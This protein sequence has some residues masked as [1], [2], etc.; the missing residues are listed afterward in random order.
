MDYAALKQSIVGALSVSEC[1]V[2]ADVAAS[3]TTTSA[4]EVGHYYGLSTAV[5]LD[6]LPPGCELVSIDHHQGDQWAPSVPVAKFEQNV[7]P[8][9]G[10]RRV[11]FINADMLDAIPDLTESFGFVFYDADHTAQAVA[12]FWRVAVDKLAARCTL[13]YDDADWAD[14][15]TLRALAEA[16]GFRVVTDRPFHRGDGDKHDP[17]T[18]TLEVM[19]RG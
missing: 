6:A 1:E 3:T 19:E 11:R 12:D 7:D 14:Q 10:D 15:S 17:R 2:L 5:L 18:Y 16:D 8:F 9:V 4:L 13:V